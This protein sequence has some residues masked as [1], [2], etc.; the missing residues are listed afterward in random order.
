MLSIV[1]LMSFRTVFVPNGRDFSLL[2]Q[3]ADTP[4]KTQSKQG[5]I[6]NSVNSLE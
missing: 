3:L 5:T 1:F 4:D 2:R 6:D